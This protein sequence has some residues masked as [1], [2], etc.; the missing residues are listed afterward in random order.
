[1]LRRNLAFALGGILLASTTAWGAPLFPDVKDEHWAKDAVAK[2]AAQGLLE[3]YPDGTFKGDRAATRWEVA[4]IV[5]RL[6][7]KMEQANAT[8]ATKAELDEVRKLAAALKDELDALGVR[9]TNLE[10]NVDRLDKR[11]TELERITFYGYV[12]TRMTT[13]TLQNNGGLGAMTSLPNGVPLINYNAAIGSSV[14]AGGLVPAAP[15]GFTLPPTFNP[16]ATSVLST[17]NWRSGRPLV[18]GVGFTSRAVLGLRINV[19]DDIDAGAEFSAYT[20]QGNQILDAYYGANP[21]SQLNAF[22]RNQATNAGFNGLNNTPQTSMVL[23]NFW[24]KHRPTNTKLLFGAYQNHSM[25]GIVYK[26]QVNPNEFGPEYLP[27]YGFQ[28]TGEHAFDEDEHTKLYWEVLGTK[29]PNGN[30]GSLP[31]Q[32][33]AGDSYYGAGYGANVKL[34]FN[35]EAGSVKLNYWRMNENFLN[36]GPRTV[37]LNVV[38]N[39]TLNWVNPNGFFRNQVGLGNSLGINSTGD[40]RPIPG[41][42]ALGADGSVANAVAAGLVPQGVPNIGGIGP[43]DQTTY[44]ISANYTFDVDDFDPRV[45]AEYGHSI[46]KP[47]AGSSYNV[48]GNALRV[49]GGAFFWDKQIEIDAHYLRVDPTYSPFIIATPTVGGLNNPMFHTP[50]F[51]FVNNLSPTHDVKTLPHNREGLRAKLL[52]KFNP[53]GRVQVEYG[54][55]TQTRSSMQDVRF[56]ANSLGVGTPNTPVLGFS[57]GFI[58]PLFQGYNRFTFAAAGGNAFAVPLED[59][60]GNVQNL[61]ISAGHKWLLEEEN[62]NRGVTL[63]GGIKTVKFFRDSN[64]STILGGPNGAAAEDQNYVDLA[65]TGWHLGVDYDVTEDFTAKVGYTHVNI[66]GHLD[67]LG[68]NSVYAS[69]V[70]TGKFDNINIAQ[71]Y[72]D[73]GFDWKIDDN[74]TWNFEGRYYKFRDQIPSYVFANPSLPTL[75]INSG[76]VTAHPF[77]WKG[78]QLNTQ[79]MVKF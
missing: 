17:F 5:A 69:T 47:N 33:G 66:H 76:P 49:G 28:I 24:V 67:P 68:V 51:Y 52:W 48:G 45:Y 18:N 4:M 1:M 19:T 12:D 10:E 23:D 63:S 56:S 31:G 54:N 14:G 60:R 15:A 21:P 43:Q 39:I 27:Q 11:V 62:N 2:L 35:D 29:L 26:G 58:D 70:G 25:D 57:P 73:I 16:F 64:M 30:V 72:P 53:T 37:G 34:S 79:F 78:L 44:G 74:V 75:N 38:P 42:P 50:D 20:A 77:S 32:P 9:V 41:L 46:Y 55:L 36:G 40:V 59:N 6:L 65:F 7:A 3:G 22:T 13:V 71:T 61:Y 8:F